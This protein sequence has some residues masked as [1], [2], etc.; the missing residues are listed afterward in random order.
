[1][2]QSVLLLALMVLPTV[3]GAVSVN[4]VTI[5]P[6]RIEEAMRTM[7]AQGAKDS[8]ELRE[9]VTRKMIESELI[10]Q[11]AVKQGIE[12]TPAF[13]AEMAAAREQILGRLLISEWARA[14]PVSDK[15]LQAE[16]DRRKAAFSGTEYQVR[17]IMVDSEAEAKNIIASLSKGGKFDELAKQKSQDKNSAA[18]GGLLG[19]GNPKQLHPAFGDALKT[20][21]RGQ[22]SKAP[23]K[24]ENAW[25]VLK[26][27]DVRQA[28]IPTLAEAREDITRQ[29][30]AQRFGAM[31]QQLQSQAKIQQ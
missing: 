18:K 6:A 20:L 30:Q 23:V 5:A 31:L 29:I 3:A 28:K 16:Y 11:E 19:W 25:H 4:G 9:M 14:N 27:D 2:R 12:K 10:I 15:D 24:S 13:K 22:F 26:V 1:M 8:P 17:H 7:K 21:G